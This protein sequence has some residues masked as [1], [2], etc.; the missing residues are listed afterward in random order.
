MRHILVRRQYGG[1]QLQRPTA[2]MITRD[3]LSGN[4]AH[5]TETPT[6]PEITR[7]TRGILH[8]KRLQEREKL[9]PKH[10]YEEN[11]HDDCSPRDADNGTE[12]SDQMV[13]ARR[14]I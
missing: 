3:I 11:F 10:I 13:N 9:I 5:I 4:I 2:Q 6:G 14:L 8:K 7:Y 1:S 12:V